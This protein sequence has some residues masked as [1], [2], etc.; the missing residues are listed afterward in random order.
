MSKKPL[1]R[2][3]AFDVFGTVV[4]WHHSI[5]REVQALG[6]PID[7]GEFANAWRARYQPSM[8]RVRTG[9][10]P[11]TR[12]DDLHRLNL[13]EVLEAYGDTSLDSAARDELNLAWHRLTPW[14][15][16]VQGLTELKKLSTICTLSNGNLAL[17]S[18]MAKAG[19][20][21]I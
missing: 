11:W 18:D 8:E 15:D 20:L 17:L 9:E 6:L 4:D 21:G 19:G 12:I 14:P 5:A 10:Q 16:T 13:D 7:G 3:L 1:P 2:V